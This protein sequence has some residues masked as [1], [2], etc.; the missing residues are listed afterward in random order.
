MLF[1]D[2]YSD[3]VLSNLEKLKS[4]KKNQIIVLMLQTSL[5][6]KEFFE[7]E[8][9]DPE[10]FGLEKNEK[11]FNREWFA[12]IFTTLQQ[13]K[14]VH[15]LSFAQF[16]YLIYYID[17]NYFFER[18]VMIRDNIR[19]L[20][21]IVK[22]DYLEK[23]EPEDIE[24]RP[25]DLP[26]YQ[27]EQIRIN[28]NY[29]YSL[30]T[31]PQP[32]NSIDLF[33]HSK[34]LEKSTNDSL[35]GIEVSS[36]PLA[37]DIFINQCIDN[38]E[39]KKEVIVKYFYKQPLNPVILDIL[40][41]LNWLLSQ[42]GGVLYI[43]EESAIAAS[44]SI[45]KETMDMLK[46]HWGDEAEFKNI[47]F[48]VNP[49]YSN[50][51]ME[52][53][54][55]FIVDTIID[56][57]ENS[58]KSGVYKDIFLTAPTGAGKSLLFQLPAFYISN[59]GDVTIV[60]SPLIALM[61]DQVDAIKRDR[62]FNKV[63]FLNSDLTLLDREIIIS[64]CRDGSIDV[65]YMSPELFLSYDLTHFI[66]SRRLGLMVI[67][68]AHLITTWGR[69]FR[70]DYWFLGNHIR[71]I[72]K[73]N[74][75]GFPMVAVTATA[76]YGGANDMIFDS[77]ESLIMRNPRIFVGE[78]KR[79]NIEFIINNHEEFDTAYE[80]KKLS[81]TVEFLKNIHTLG[82]KTLVYAPY[83]KHIKKI[84]SE[85]N[86]E[87]LNI[88]TG[89]YGTLDRGNRELAFREFKNGDKKIMI[90]T[91]AF[92]MGVDIP[93]IQVVYHHAPSGLLPDYIQEIGR[94]AR[95]PNI[96]GFATIN[97]SSQDQRFTK[98]LHGM[99][100]I[101][102]FQ[103]REVLKK[104][105]KLFLKHNKSRN[106]LISVDDFSHIF[107]D[108]R[109]IDQKVLTA[110][111]MIEKDYLAKNRFNVIVARPKKLFVR[112]YAKISDDHFKKIAIIY[113][114]T[115]TLINTLANNN[116]I[117]EIDLD[118]LWKNHY[119]NKSF[120]VLKYEFYK[121][122]LLEKEG[123]ELT[124]MLRMSFEI[125]NTFKIV[126]EKI[127][128]FLKK[129]IS[130]F[131]NIST[132]FTEIDFHKKLNLFLNNSDKSEKLSKFILS[133]YSGRMLGPGSIE[134]GAFLQ[135]REQNENTEYRVFSTRY[136]ENF[137]ALLISLK[138]IYINPDNSVAEIY[139]TNK[140]INTIQQVRLGS[141]LEIL[142]LGTFEIKGGSNPM[143]FL[144]INDPNRVE[145]D[146]NDPGYTNSLLT[147]TLQRHYLSNQIFDLFF[148]Q[149]FTN[150]ERW[151]FVEDFFLGSDIDALHDKYNGK[152]LNKIDI[153]GELKKKDL[154]VAEKELSVT[155]R[156]E[157]DIFFP[158]KDRTYFFGDLMTLSNMGLI[159]T[160]KVTEWVSN[161][162]TFFDKS[163]KE[164]PFK[165]SKDVF[166]ILIS[167]I[168]SDYPEYYSAALGLH[169]RIKFKGYDKPVQA[170]V[171]YSTTPVEF[172]K[173][174]L[175]N[176][177]IVTLTNKEKITLFV[178]VEDLSKGILTKEHKRMISKK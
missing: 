126:Y 110:L 9:A 108:H 177:D 160:M 6:K 34:E 163:R 129:V 84:L 145:K 23:D 173:W 102:P 69:D 45:R 101:K 130:I 138:N 165:I 74:Q 169:V 176:Q 79:N 24:R 148:L 36:D 18:V 174:W 10:T 170:S 107:E 67:D 8:I 27:A 111:M 70:V 56:E 128:S 37:L 121:G 131:E 61:K 97:Y 73:F 156:L 112:V 162:P 52:L 99:S 13:T 85:L 161:D 98:A 154:P 47:S 1:K 5:L 80:K 153:I 150:T 17:P 87:Y 89:Y 15:I 140:E 118:K 12:R 88:A 66:G 75:I 142:E 167:K 2:Y 55:G 172:Y 119:S 43:F 39:F 51:L 42:F 46:L 134:P 81:Q 139:L 82:L 77:L 164:I 11:V 151:N 95:R 29:Y 146:S 147:K 35:E 78:V 49:N 38:N 68:E 3:L 124:P 96:Q 105:Y 143:I 149:S 113:P 21:P 92:G 178:K 109:D 133:S 114:D 62:K 152:E 26:L 32:F 65:L 86:H 100:S 83:S 141:L 54:Q 50:E 60:I 28:N 30:K 166:E 48:Y 22:E 103:L 58:K 90:S 57:Y 7:S 158:N 122:K 33:I 125:L 123:I 14:E 41:K 159:R 135:R 132:Y 171:P 94:I 155:D 53:S 93:D 157:T 127:E 63:S 20:F 25:D 71:K 117:L 137:N 106:L 175:K 115:Y 64:N 104:L 168:R 16:S 76:V 72:R 19:Q 4:E 91:K 44:G 120:P 31:L 144:R 136:L 116:K 59:K 40:K